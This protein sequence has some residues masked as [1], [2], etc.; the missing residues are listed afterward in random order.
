MKTIEP[1]RMNYR[2][3][4]G[5]PPRKCTAPWVACVGGEPDPSIN[6]ETHCVHYH[7]GRDCDMAHYA[8]G[9]KLWAFCG[10]VCGYFETRIDP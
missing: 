4:E 3:E 1:K 8:G 9:D 10:P 7:E 2:Y 5:N 6:C